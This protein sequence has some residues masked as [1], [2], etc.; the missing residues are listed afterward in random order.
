MN[1]NMFKKFFTKVGSFIKSVPGIVKKVPELIKKIPFNKVGS[2]AKSA[3]GW[4][5]GIASKA[6]GAIKGVCAGIKAFFKP[7]AEVAATVA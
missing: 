6:P 4:I 3:W 5:K 2:A 7:A 1:T